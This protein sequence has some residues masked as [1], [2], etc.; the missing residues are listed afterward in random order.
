MMRIWSTCK[1]G[2][3]SP[4]PIRYK[5]SISWHVCSVGA[6]F[7]TRKDLPLLSRKFS[8]GEKS[9][10]ILKIYEIGNQKRPV[11]SE[12]IFPCDRHLSAGREERGDLKAHQA[13]GKRAPL[14]GG[15][16]GGARGSAGGPVSASERGARTA[17]RPQRCLSRNAVPLGQRYR[18]DLR[19][20]APSLQRFFF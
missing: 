15:R 16:L 18:C 19:R 9:I 2:R 6:S 8:I 7:A 14:R 13:T 11:L 12:S 4:K 10:Q 5:R 17:P 20:A 1:R 3:S